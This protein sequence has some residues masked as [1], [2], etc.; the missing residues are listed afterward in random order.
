MAITL[1]PVHNTIYRNASCRALAA[2]SCIPEERADLPGDRDLL[3]E[4]LNRRIAWIRL[5]P[6]SREEQTITSI[7]P[8]VRINV[9]S[10]FAPVMEGFQAKAC[11]TWISC[12]V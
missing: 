1:R 2:F 3:T 11:P 4:A 7:P 8:S 12:C 9:S 5:D 6:H 10:A